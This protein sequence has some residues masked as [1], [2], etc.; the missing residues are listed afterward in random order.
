MLSFTTAHVAVIALRVKDPDRERPYRMPWNVRI[1]GASIP[2]SAVLG[3]IGTFAA[4]CSVV[5]LHGEARLVGI[6]WMVVGLTGYVL[7]RRSQHLDLRSQ[8]RIL[9][10]ERPAGFQALEYRTA[11]VPIF[12]GDV[13][14]ETLSTAGK[15]IGEDGVVY[16]VYVLPVPSQLSLG[17]GL[18]EEEAEGRSLLETARIKGRRAG[19]K[20]HTDLVRTRNPGA[21][22]VEE[23]KRHNSDVIYLSTRHAP[24]NEQ[25]IGPLAAYLLSR[26]PCRIIIET[27]PADRARP[28][29]PRPLAATGPGG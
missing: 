24:A 3:G 13:S 4:W 14:L 20:I 19:L 1:R 16:A 9:R 15:L 23:A 11:L 29:A 28:A 12:G 6:P 18:E 22:L 8:H 27:E 25:R 5:A 2:L 26:R 17:A 10:P 21:T 7:Y